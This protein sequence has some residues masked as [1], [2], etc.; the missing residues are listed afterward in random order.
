MRLARDQ[1]HDPV[2]A[3]G[4]RLA[5]DRRERA[6]AIAEF[7]RVRLLRAA[8]AEASQRGCRNT[9]VAS[10]IARAGVSRATFYQQFENREDCF[11]AVFEQCIAEIAHVVVPQYAT[12]GGWPERIRRALRAL[13][14]FLEAEREVGEFV[15]GQ[16]IGYPHVE[17]ERSA[18]VL[19][20]L[21]DALEDGR[22]QGVSCHEPAP[23]TAETVLGGALAVIEARLRTRPRGLTALLNELM[24]MIV[25]PYRGPAVA[26]EE[27]RRPLPR[28]RAKPSE[29]SAA[30]PGLPDARLGG[31]DKRLTY[32]A[33]T[34]L[35]AIAREPGA[36]NVE[37]A[38][39]VRIADQSQISKLLARLERQGL[40]ENVPRG[41]PIGAANAWRVTSRGAEV[42]SALRRAHA[43]RARGRKER[44]DA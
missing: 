32:R 22:S 28:P 8:L 42:D 9:P 23:L 1:P 6:V 21:R 44:G 17:H 27:L 3:A 24:W 40:I 10:I 18:L 37:L 7:Q 39:R 5:A 15:L 14:A 31:P 2:R 43:I 25:L 19:A 30:R 36:S 16:V 26:D 34:V 13:L 11:T 38:L 35:A 20:R 29:S 41:H 4:S 12:R 33:A